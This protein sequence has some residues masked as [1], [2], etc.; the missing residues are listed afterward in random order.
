MCWF[1]SGVASQRKL[2]NFCEPLSFA[3]AAVM[4]ERDTKESQC[5]I[6]PSLKSLDSSF[7]IS[8]DG[9]HSPQLIM[10]RRLA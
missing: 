5:R 8:A 3:K 9:A 2:A 1:A 10:P 7:Q 4:V 6:L